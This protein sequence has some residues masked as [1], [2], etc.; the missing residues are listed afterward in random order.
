M[1]GSLSPVR[2]LLGLTLLFLA[3][4]VSALSA[5]GPEAL[6]GAEATVWWVWPLALLVL[7][8]VMGILAA[9]GGIG[10]GVL[11]VPIVSAFFPFHFDFV[12]GA[13]LL[14][15]LSGALAAGPGFLRMN[16][17]SLRLAMPL[18]LMAST[19]AI[20]G[21]GA[22]QVLPV[23]LVETAMGFTILG[24]V[25]LMMIARKST[26]PHVPEPDRLSSALRIAG[27]FTEAS[28][29]REVSWKV[30]RT[31]TSLILFMFIG[32]IAGMFGL[33]AGWANVPAL[34]LVMGAPLKISVATSKFLLSITDTS[35]VWVYLNSGAIIPMM[36][37]PSIVGI[38]GGSFIGVRILR[39]AKPSFVKWIV[40]GLLLF[41]GIKTITKGLSI[42]F[43]F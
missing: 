22:G 4:P 25:I 30:H 14:V 21:A 15:A 3:E 8:F 36:V 31:P 18:A 37:V 43:I 41:C 27:V 11:F 6:P 19:F 38:M 12:R 5:Q 29:G 39:V 35:A 23:R 26:Y 40:I 28:L 42:P 1:R 24:I 34:N 10:G 16:L 2:I 32:F 9:L 33:G 17:A 20:F 13:G 7:T